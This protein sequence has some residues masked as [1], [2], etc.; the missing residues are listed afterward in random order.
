MH[1]KGAT[2]VKRCK[3]N[4]YLWQPDE[5]WSA[6]AGLSGDVEILQWLRARHVP[7]NNRPVVNA[8]ESGHLDVVRWYHA[9]GGGL[10]GVSRG[11]ATRH[12]IGMPKRCYANGV[13]EEA[14][15]GAADGNSVLE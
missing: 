3:E 8:V 5:G 2:V 13:V 10:E 4:G 11:A 7:W 6:Y 15:Y 9:N 14:L 1:E 12:F